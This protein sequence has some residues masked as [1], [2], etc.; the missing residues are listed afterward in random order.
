MALTQ[1]STSVREAPA[2]GQP[3]AELRQVCKY[4]GSVRALDGVDF[5]IFPNEV[6]ALVGDNGAGKSTLIKVLS[7]AHEPTKAKPR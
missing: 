4:Y 2:N 5:Q 3:L 7:G 1:A 6:H